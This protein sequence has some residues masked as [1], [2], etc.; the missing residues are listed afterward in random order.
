MA[1]PLFEGGG[2]RFKIVEAFAAGLPVISSAIGIEALGAIVGEHFLPAETPD[3]FISTI[4]NLTRDQDMRKRLVHSASDFAERY[5]WR[6]VGQ[7][8]RAALH[9]L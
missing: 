6:A 8:I 2:T 4:E 3:E 1:V 5:S 7:S 9:D